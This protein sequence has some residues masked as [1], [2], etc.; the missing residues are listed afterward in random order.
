MKIL[1]IEDEEAIRETL[2]I[3]L[4]MNGYEVANAP[5]GETGVTLAAQA[6]D[7][8]LCDIGLPGID[9]YEVL[10]RVR[11]NPASRDV[12]FVFLTAHADRGA[13]RRGMELGADDYVTKP[14]TEHDIVQAIQARIRRQAPL[15][16]RVQQLLAERRS[17]AQADWSHELMTPLN[18][19]L[20]GLELIE[21]EADSIRPAE[22]K[23]LLSLVRAGAERQHMLSKKL[24][25]FH[26]LEREKAGPP[27]PDRRCEAG[28]V[29]PPAAE[30][31]AAAERRRADLQ[32]DCEPGRIGLDMAHVTAAVR[33]LV[34]NAARYSPVGTPIRVTGRAEAGGY[35]IEVADEGEGL[36]AEEQGHVGPFVRFRRPGEMRPG[37]GLG[38]A[39]AEAVAQIGGGTMRGH[40]GP[41]GEGWRVEL[42]FKAPA[43]A[44][45]AAGQ[46]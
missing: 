30:A 21:S 39:I 1:V 17:Q 3:L 18:G 19:V 13:Q 33:E 25:L 22:L 45:A 20:G 14:F 41:G 26:E 43:A 31:A 5:D 24:V 38:L 42:E 16:E 37:L 11:E 35:R 34:E 10:K 12:P 23:E 44:G 8:I 27:R 32:V 4:E 2:V 9:G 6:P 7:L 40:R 29:V 28:L 36:T 46:K 15:K